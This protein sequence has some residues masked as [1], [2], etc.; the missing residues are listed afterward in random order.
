M[1]AYQLTAVSCCKK[2]ASEMKW[3]IANLTVC[4]KSVWLL[5]F[6][7][8][9]FFDSLSVVTSFQAVIKNLCLHK[10]L[11]S[12]PSTSKAVPGLALVSPGVRPATA[13]HSLAWPTSNIESSNLAWISHLGGRWIFQ[14]IF[15]RDSCHQL[16]TA[17][18]SC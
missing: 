8:L 4:Q 14:L 16:S 9:L 7:I 3:G 12:G 13:S 15:F 18:N 1:T 6:E 5:E 17:D 10:L 2:M 11:N